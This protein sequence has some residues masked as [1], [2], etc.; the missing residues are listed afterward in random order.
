M[1]LA[2]NLL[3]EFSMLLEII[4]HGD[5]IRGKV[6]FQKLVFLSQISMGKKYNYNFE[7]AP[8]GPLS[9]RV[10]YILGRMTELGVIDETI[11]STHSGNDVYCY[12]ITDIGREI[13][14]FAK[15][16]EVLGKKE[17]KTIDVVYKKYGQMSYVQ[18]L[19]YVHNK[20]PEYHLKNVTLY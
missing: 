9:D 1:S 18:L 7:P 12:K 5:E 6:R 20:Y 13:L 8:L 2:T 16:N 3:R 15:K 17:I 4:S 11:R 14:E 10:N 19:D